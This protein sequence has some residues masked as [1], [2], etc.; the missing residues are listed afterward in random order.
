MSNLG[1]QFRDDDRGMTLVELLTGLGLG[2]VVLAAALTIFLN[3][4][5]GAATVQDRADASQRARLGFD[6][7]TAL[8]GAQV[9]NGVTNAGTPVVAAD[10]NAVSFTANTDDADAT[11]TG[12]KLRYNAAA[13]ELWEDS[14]PLVGAE[15]AAGYRTWGTTIAASRQL[16]DNAVPDGSTP[17]FRYY[18]VSNSTT[19]NFVELDPDGSGLTADERSRVLRIDLSL[20][21]LP[22]R[23]SSLEARGTLMQTESYV[24]SN[25]VA[26]SLDQGPRC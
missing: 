4:M 15:N 6:R 5:S 9:C 10:P 21:I 20:K 25:V 12:Y 14:Y 17:V 26:G 18:G 3:G 8:V 23:T 24:T 16:L 22:T 1:E 13:D 11:P 7:V 19:G 2:S